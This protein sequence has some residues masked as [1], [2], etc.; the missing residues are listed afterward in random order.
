MATKEISPFFFFSHFSRSPSK[1]SFSSF[2]LVITPL[3]SQH[4]PSPTIY[5]AVPFVSFFHSLYSF[6][7]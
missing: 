1:V 5:L 2:P 3:F 4:N 6:L 7:A